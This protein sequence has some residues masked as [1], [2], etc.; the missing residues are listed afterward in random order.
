[1]QS[2]TNFLINNWSNAQLMI[3]ICNIYNIYV[4]IHIHVYIYI[5]IQKSNKN[6][7]DNGI[8]NKVLFEIIYQ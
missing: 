6:I 1:M 2:S 3:D 7:H 5:H 4:Y 8:P